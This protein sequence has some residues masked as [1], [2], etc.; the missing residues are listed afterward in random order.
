M[1]MVTI[2]PN[3]T[4]GIN[5]D[6]FGAASTHAALSDAS[7]ASYVQL[8]FSAPRRV[9][10]TNPTKPAGSMLWK[11]QPRARIGPQ[12]PAT[13]CAGEF[14][15]SLN[16]GY[17]IGHS[18]HSVTT[19]VDAA[20]P[21]SARW[22]DLPQVTLDGI[23]FE[24][25][26]L[27]APT[28]IRYYKAD[29]DVYFADQ[30][31]TTIVSPASGAALTSADFD[32]FF[33]HTPG[34][35]HGFVQ[36]AYQW[37]LYTEAQYSGAGFV[38]G[39]TPALIS[40]GPWLNRNGGH[41]VTGVPEGAHR[42][43]V[44]TA[45][46]VNGMLHWAPYV[47]HPITVTY[48]R[49]EVLDLALTPVNSIGAN[50]VIVNRDTGS[51]AWTGVHVQANEGTNLLAS[52]GQMGSASGGTVTGG[53]VTDVG[54]FRYHTFTSSGTLTVTGSVPVNYLVVGGGGGGGSSVGGG[55]G[56][57]GYLAGSTTLSTSQ[58]VT[59]GAA[60]SAGVG[61]VGGS[62]GNSALGS[63]AVATGGG[64]GAG[65]GVNATSGGSGGGGSGASTAGA[66]TAG[67][68][69]AGGAGVLDR[70]GG[71]GGGA[72]AVGVAGTSSASGAGGA[73][74]VWSDGVQYAGGG[75]AGGYNTFS[76]PAGAGG[77]GG[78][79]AGG[80]MSP[81]GVGSAGTTNRGGGGGGGAV[82]QNGGA[83]GSGVV[84][85]RYVAGDIAAGWAAYQFGSPTST[86]RSI[87][88][89]GAGGRGDYQ[90]LVST[91]TNVTAY[92]ITPSFVA[93]DEVQS[94]Q[95]VELSVDYKGTFAA[96]S[97]VNLIIQWFDAVSALIGD[98]RT[99]HTPVTT[100]AWKRLSA[101][102]QAPDDAVEMAII[103]EQTASTGTAVA[104]TLD[105]DEVRWVVDGEW[106][107]VRYTFDEIP[108]ANQFT[109]YDYEASNDKP[110]RYRARALTNALIGAWVEQV[111]TTTWTVDGV[112]VWVKHP[113]P[114]LNALLEFGE[115]PQPD[116]G[117]PRAVLDIVNG[118]YPVTISDRRKGRSGELT[119]RTS[120]AD[121]AAALEV[122]LD[123]PVLLIQPSAAY[124]MD[125]GWWSL[126]D[127]GE[128]HIWN[129]VSTDDPERHWPVS[130][131]E[132]SRP[133]TSRT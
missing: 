104:A 65:D 125:S 105:V 86:S 46:S 58:T 35:P 76:V 41:G 91:N 34:N 1:T 61:G 37:H 2:T 92:G 51:L 27:G 8:G 100:T 90:R 23:E 32:L 132:V 5:A 29:V 9:T 75:G 6:F 7:D 123:K 77:A 55:G 112:G 69:F 93:D 42:I 128:R 120:T 129:Y 133:S 74:T 130:V 111:G 24:F 49:G 80:V 50:Q 101:I 28:G 39:V 15:V 63:V 54:G 98:T 52:I 53:T 115:L 13:L 122:L 68:G 71:G 20:G 66:G 113:N 62:G 82:S 40:S 94:G 72:A 124:R 26:S 126:G 110:I 114:Q 44:R 131:T 11:V 48:A 109:I 3:G 127:T 95:L 59:V 33:Q 47:F 97:R 96:T 57:G 12:A 64:G 119:F 70:S 10:M 102:H 4:V 103:I 78:G 108:S 30:P 31:S 87:Q 38:A 21:Q 106:R 116:R 43:Y 73:G 67:Q 89:G 22:F 99:Q 79:G 18:Q 25:R 45:Q 118:R 107:D 88:T 84:I 117:R 14:W 36:A 60:G 81:P 83:G 85:V 19:I 56:A 17:D 16:G 121:Q